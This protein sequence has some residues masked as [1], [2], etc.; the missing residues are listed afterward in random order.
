M[1]ES[2]VKEATLLPDNGDSEC[3][4]IDANW[5]AD[6]EKAKSE[7]KPLPWK[8]IDRWLES[9][10]R[11]GNIYAGVLYPTIGYGIKGVI[12]YQGESDYGRPGEYTDLFSLMIEEWRKDWNEGDFPFYWVQLPKYRTTQPDGEKSGWVQIREAQTRTLSQ[13]NTAEVV[14]ID[15]GEA[16]NIHPRSK[17]EVAARLARVALARDY[18]IPVKYRSAI[19]KALIG[20]GNKA[21]IVFDCF[22]SKLMTLNRDEVDGFTICGPDKKWWA[23][24]GRLVDD[25]TVEVWS[26]HVQVPL[27]V[28][29]DWSEIPEGNLYTDDARLPVTPF[30]TEANR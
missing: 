16:N 15:L 6:C 2:A 13:P 17:Q 12:W 9:A 21:D 29:Y 26:D 30:T 28:R 19:F 24:Q 27:A 3:A 14:T 20:K 4:R 5:K 25:H 1:A 18:G 7:G 22:N 8:P 11:P 10:K 23:A